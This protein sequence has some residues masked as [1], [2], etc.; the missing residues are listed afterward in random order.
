MS[1]CAHFTDRKTMTQRGYRRVQGLSKNMTKVG[2]VA[3]SIGYLPHPKYMFSL[4]FI[5]TQP[6]VLRWASQT[7]FV[8]LPFN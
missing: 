7:L 1:Y 4:S 5:E 8:S 2:V 3:E 6:P